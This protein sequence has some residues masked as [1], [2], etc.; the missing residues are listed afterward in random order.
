MKHEQISHS[1]SKLP[2]IHGKVASVQNFGETESVK[3]S[4]A[5]GESSYIPKKF[6]KV[7][8]AGRMQSEEKSK[9]IYL[10]DQKMLMQRQ[11][12]DLNS[13]SFK[14]LY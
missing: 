6:S 2:S 11:S 4:K 5:P 1:R 13:K 10:S 9:K 12:V 14:R 3:S 7:S 8:G